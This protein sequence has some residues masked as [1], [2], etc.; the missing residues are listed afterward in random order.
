M[1]KGQIFGSGSEQRRREERREELEMWRMMRIERQRTIDNIIEDLHNDITS[2][3]KVSGLNLNETG[4][5]NYISKYH[6]MISKIRDKIAHA[7]II[8]HKHTIEPTFCRGPIVGL[9]I[10]YYTDYSYPKPPEQHEPLE[11]QINHTDVQC[12]VL[13]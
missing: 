10:Y 2:T 7:K 13:L 11:P 4:Y 1:G 12:C 3:W 5:N 6:N 9:T 8:I